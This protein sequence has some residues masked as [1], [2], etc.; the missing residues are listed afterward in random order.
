MS[1]RARNIW[2]VIPF[3]A[4][5]AAIVAGLIVFTS[6][7]PCPLAIQFV[8]FTNDAARY[9]VF[10]VTN[11]SDR[12]LRFR[13][14]TE[15]K[16]GGSWPIYPVGTVL[17]HYNS[18]DSGSYD[19]AAHQRRALHAYLPADGTAIR[20]SI[21]CEEPWT[22]W[23]SFRWSVSVWFHDHNLPRVGEF[24]SEGKHGHLILSSEIHR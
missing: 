21:A 12:P 10:S 5:C 18:L 7:K 16:A 15:P 2:T 6:E 24:V 20:M 14:I 3:L 8:G 19:I 22:R 17:P 11:R 1:T 9:G 13:A 23:E 4:F